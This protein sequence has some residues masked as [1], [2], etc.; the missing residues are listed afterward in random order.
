[1]IAARN[2]LHGTLHDLDN[3]ELDLPALD[4][5]LIAAAALAPKQ[6]RWHLSYDCEGTPFDFDCQAPSSPEAD[7]QGR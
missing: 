3:A 1:M 4:M 7:H 2:T 6:R 5:N